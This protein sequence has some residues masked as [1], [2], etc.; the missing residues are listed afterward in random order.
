MDTSVYRVTADIVAGVD[1]RHPVHLD[2][3]IAN[4]WA[5]RH[6]V[7]DYPSHADTR[8]V[9]CRSLDVQR[10]NLRG[11][12]YVEAL[13]SGLWLCS[14]WMME[15]EPHRVPHWYTRRRD[16]V[17]QDLAASPYTPGSGPSR[18]VL[19]R[20]ELVLIRRASWLGVGSASEARKALRLVSHVGATRRQGCGAVR[21]WEVERVDLDP[22]RA[23]V[24]ADGVALRHIPAIWCTHIEGPVSALTVRAPYFGRRLTEPAVSLG[25]R[26]VLHDDVVAAVRRACGC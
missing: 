4:A 11:L 22:M 3:L 24:D 2:A 15:S 14:A 1:A 20:K 16:A 18:D 10:P 9:H 23:I 21:S 7:R 17:D 13:G 8:D 19:A 6:G 12:R 25:A 5:K 26:V